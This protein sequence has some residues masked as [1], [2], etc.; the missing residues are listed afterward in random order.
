[1]CGSLEKKRKKG[2][3]MVEGQCN[4]GLKLI[5]GPPTMSALTIKR[6][7]MQMMLPLYHTK[8]MMHRNLC[9]MIC[10]LMVTIYLM[11]VRV[12]PVMTG[13]MK[14]T[15]SVMKCVF[16]EPLVEHTKEIVP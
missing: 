5:Y 11:K 16:V 10:P 14:M 9:Q 7:Y 12:P 15:S 2:Q 8:S 6:E 4:V 3:N 13:A 1:V